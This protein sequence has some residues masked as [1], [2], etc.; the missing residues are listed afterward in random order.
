VNRK[1]RR[2]GEHAGPYG[3]TL[4]VPFGPFLQLQLEQLTLCQALD[5]L[6]RRCPAA[7]V[8][9]GETGFEVPLCEEKD[10]PTL[11]VL[12]LVQWDS[13]CDP[14]SISYAPRRQ[15]PKMPDFPFPVWG[16]ELAVETYRYG[17]GMWKRHPSAPCQKCTHGFWVPL[18][19]CRWTGRR[20]FAIFKST[21]MP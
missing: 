20:G 18:R 16:T 3:S 10:K 9:Y 15:N 1:R 14:T 2:T 19:G 13:Q 12:E 8:I 4:N 5:L 11:S 6:T 21:A 7:S 17:T